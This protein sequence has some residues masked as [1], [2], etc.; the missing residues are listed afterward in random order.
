[1]ADQTNIPEA[2]ASVT[3]SVIS[4]DGYNALFTI[5]GTSG[6]DLLE[7]MGTIEK[8]LASKGYKPQVK[9]SFGVKKE[10]E[11]IEGRSCPV[12]K[13]RLVSRTKKDGEKYEQCENY[14]YDFTQ[15]KNIG[16]CGYIKFD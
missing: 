15:K 11:Y 1:M 2:V 14:K 10:V 4:K 7:T 5:R 3:Y 6:A 16:S 9:Q 12:C 8:V 13:N